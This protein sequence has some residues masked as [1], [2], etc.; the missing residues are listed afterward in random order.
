MNIRV[1]LAASLALALLLSVLAVPI[2][3]AYAADEYDTLREKWKTMLT[4]GNAYSTSDADIAAQVTAITNEAQSYW[5]SLNT[6]AS[7]TYLWS[8]LAS[9]TDSTHPKIS[10][11]RLKA[12]ATAYSTHGSALEA[13]AALGADIVSALD[14]LYVNRYNETVTAYGNWFD[15]EIGAPLAL[16]DIVVLMYDELTAMQRTNYMNAIYHFSP[17]VSLSGANR[18]WKSTVV[19]LR[20]ILIKNGTKIGEARNG[21]SAVFD[22]TTSGDGFYRDGSFIQHNN[23]PYTGGYGISLLS[24]IANLMDVLSGSTWQTTDTDQ[25]NVFRWVYDS[26]QPLLYK[27]AMMDMVRGREI[28]RYT[29]QDHVAGHKALQA[30][31][32]LAQFAPAADAAAFKSIVKAHLQQDTFRSFYADA[33]VQ[34]I[35][36]AKAI[37]GDGTIAPAAALS[38]QKHFAAMDRTVLLRPGFGFGIGMYSSRIYNYESINAENLKGWYTGYGTTYLYNGDLDQFSDDYWATVNKYRLPGTTVS[39]QTRANSSS[40]STLSGKSWVGGATLAGTYGVSGMELDL[41]A[42]KSWFMFDDEVAALGSGIT[43]ATGNRVETIVENRKINA[44]GSNALTVGGAAK[45]SSLGWSEA[46]TGVSWAHLAGSAAGGDI[47]YYFPQPVALN[48]LREARTG[49][50]SEMNTYSSFNVTTPVTRNYLTL[51]LDHGVNPTNAS[52]QYVLLPGKTS[53][54]VGAYAANPGVVVLENSADAHAVK[55]TGLNIV[56]ANFWNDGTK[57]IALGGSSLMTSDKKASV[58]TRETSGQLDI[59]VADPTQANTGAITLEIN[60]A[61]YSVVS[62]DPGVTVTQLS[63]TVRLQVNVSG[64]KGKTFQTKLSLVPT[65][66]TYEV[67]GLSAT[68]SSGDTRTTHND[69]NASSGRFDKLNANAVND[70][71]EYTAN[72]PA[73]GTYTVKA[74]VKK[75]SD[76]GKLQ[77]RVDGAIVGTEQDEYTAAGEVYE[78]L[79]LGTATFAASGS[80]TFRFTVTGKN[81]S[82]TGYVLAFDTIRLE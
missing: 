22:Y 67:E 13:N 52:Y 55:E 74:R 17:S 4:G 46:M 31:I 14:W 36:L 12:M 78:E 56:A 62:A 81:A 50:W 10:Y 57:T 54:Q 21:L 9:T 37:A 58:M 7:R 18:V 47:G 28:S 44:A 41:A 27:G 25:A 42:R 38:L 68:V 65:P 26:Y 48:G 33:T 34:T 8:D 77:L 71:I 64:A 53:A 79:T 45:S 29:M 19:G 11:Q 49:S 51:W 80:H 76:R 5:S 61:A 23:H 70:Y 15:W 43:R 2:R 63:P 20:G 6:S 35:V 39:T 69:T 30:I 75:L 60:R 16:N 40:Q 59:A 73:A 3:P 1:I 82:S 72:V 66:V 32:R 24:D